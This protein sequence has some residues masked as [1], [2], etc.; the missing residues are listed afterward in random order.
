MFN[1]FDSKLN[2]ISSKPLEQV[3]FDSTEIFLLTAFN[4]S[5]FQCINNINN[6]ITS[7][8]NKIEKQ[9]S[10]KVKSFVGK[11]SR[12]RG[13][14][15]CCKRRKK[16]CDEIKPICG[17]CKRLKF[18]CEFKE[19]INENKNRYYHKDHQQAKKMY[20]V[21]QNELTDDNLSQP[22][23]NE[24]IPSIDFNKQLEQI[25]NIE[26]EYFSQNNYEMQIT[27]DQFNKV[28][29]FNNS[30]VLNPNSLSPYSM[31]N[32]ALKSPE[33]MNFMLDPKL[34][35]EPTDFIS[36][37]L[38]KRGL[39]FFDYYRFNLC[40]AISV[41]GD[42][43]NFFKTYFIT[44]ANQDISILYA[45]VAWG[46]AFLVNR[47][48][49]DVSKYLEE[50]EN[51]IDKRN[52]A[53]YN[54]RSEYMTMLS[55]C[56]IAKG[57]NVSTG[58]TKSWYKYMKKFRNVLD[59]YGGL[60]KFCS[61]NI[62]ENEAK[63]LISNFF[64]HD[65]IN[66]HSLQNETLI[67]LIDYITVFKEQK[68]LEIGNFGLDPSSGC[69]TEA[70]IL[71][72]EIS[73]VRHSLKKMEK[74]I[75]NFNH[76][77]ND[78]SALVDINVND[79]NMDSYFILNL[80]S[81]KRKALKTFEKKINNLKPSVTRLLTILDDY[82]LLELHLTFFELYQYVLKI[83]VLIM[84]KGVKSNDLELESL[85]NDLI[86]RFDIIIGSKL[87]KCLCFPLLII[88]MCCCLKSRRDMFNS[89]YDLLCS[90]Y[91]LKNVTRMREMVLKC[92][93]I[94]DENKDMTL[95]ECFEISKDLLNE[96][97]CFS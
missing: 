53:K 58:D 41:S 9:H 45:L 40:E 80:K 18:K 59:K 46:G 97:V 6:N 10:I 94:F 69:A 61:D 31:W 8:N 56:L 47:D 84:I 37:H 76:G 82:L 42:Q 3:N 13:G 43:D 7:T 66:S 28:E 5:D 51:S 19:L 39:L 81:I 12:S 63:W 11:T 23:K 74:S 93:D 33:F 48:E 71:I 62:Y 88:G 83:C 15:L 16:K 30:D 96:K 78:V 57:I 54:S 87:E 21:T 73:S 36:Q 1:T 26:N 68:L 24:Y 4:G 91:I 25:D 29:L 2:N 52:L 27:E 70:V 90:S 38:D 60:Q 34:L 75:S 55:F 86:L 17:S 14:C 50:A 89:R 67:P 65:V 85:F 64:Y 22:R 32:S 77:F 20:K 79:S 95:D 92:W 72:A 44:L 35:Y 49:E